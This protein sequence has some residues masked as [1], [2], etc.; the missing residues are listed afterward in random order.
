[1]IDPQGQANRWIRRF[2]KDKG[3]VIMK[4]SDATYLRQL[5][6]AIRN[7]NPVLLENVEEVL[8]PALE[9]V[10]NKSIVKRGGE[11]VL[12]LGDTDVPYDENFA[13]NITTK[14]AN[15]HYLPEICIKV[16]VINFTVTLLGLE[17]QL[18]ADVVASERPDLAAARSNLAVQIA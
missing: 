5:E 2:G 4:L 15:P 18:A 17:D 7:G 11:M 1:M 9:P 3:V 13:L 6:A 14:M 16:T 12:R 10:L 8:D